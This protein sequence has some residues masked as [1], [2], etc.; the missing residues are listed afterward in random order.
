MGIYDILPDG[1]QL[2]CWKCEMKVLNIG[3]KV[4]KIDGEKDYIVV[5][6]EGGYVEVSRKRIVDI[7]EDR[8]K[9]HIVALELPMF[10]KYGNRIYDTNGLEGI[11][12]G[13]YYY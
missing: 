8:K 1:S 13:D 6:R 3:S 10:D 2:K 4:G 11:F 7:V 9:H 5:L 12:G